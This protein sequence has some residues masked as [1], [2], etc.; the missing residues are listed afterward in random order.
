MKALAA[1]IIIVKS[2]G[3]RIT[4][5]LIKEMIETARKFS[6]QPNA[7]WTDQL[8]NFDHI[9]GYHPLGEE[10]WNQTEGK[11]DAF[12]HCV[13]TAASL[14][15][16][17]TILKEQNPRIK[18]FA[19]EPAESPVLSGGAS[20]AHN[21]EGIGIGFDPPLWKPE[22]ADEIFQIPTD[23]AK[24]M[25]RRLATEEAIFAGTSSGPNVI[26]AIEL[27]KRL[28]P[29]ATVVTLLIDNGLKYLSTDVFIQP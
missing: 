4:E 9:A 19:V 5:K 3:E 22:I 15:G 1:E 20:G 21:I 28:G 18:I 13:G 26:A 8:N 11:V 25:A 17:S 27:A 16:I 14:T 2:E 6:E 10:I 7:Y 29:S 12:V 23:E 24:A